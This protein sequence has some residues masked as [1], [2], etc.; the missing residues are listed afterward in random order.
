MLYEA[1]KDQKTADAWR[2]EAI[3][4]DNE[5]QVYITVF[6]EPLAEQRALEYA[7]VMNCI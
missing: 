3:D 1:I 2:V 7:A 4:Y 6:F 5:G